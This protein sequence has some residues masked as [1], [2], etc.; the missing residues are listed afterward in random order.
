M[1]RVFLAEAG[2]QNSSQLTLAENAIVIAEPQ[3]G[4]FGAASARR[5]H[6]RIFPAR[7]QPLLVTHSDEAICPRG[8]WTT[9]HKGA[10]PE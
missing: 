8:N 7:S 6:S 3:L 9:P 2:D 1:A 4:K 10:F 5:R